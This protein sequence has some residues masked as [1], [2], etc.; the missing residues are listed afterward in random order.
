MQL[1]GI[2]CCLGKPKPHQTYIL[3]SHHTTCWTRCS[4]VRYKLH[5]IV[6]C[7]QASIY[8]DINNTFTYIWCIKKTD[9]CVCGHVYKM[10]IEKKQGFWTLLWSS[11][12]EETHFVR[13][14]PIRCTP[15]EAQNQAA[16]RWM[17]VCVC[18][19]C[20]EYVHKNVYACIYMCVGF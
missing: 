16:E 10:W 19:I 3:K 6:Q 17:C 12:R 11:N 7:K 9:T 1:C 2:L 5:H 4:K 14:R 20:D 15:R 8:M 18:N 13:S